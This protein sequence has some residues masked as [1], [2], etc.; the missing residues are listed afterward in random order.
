MHGFSV[1]V[2]QNR[3]SPEE[4]YSRAQNQSLLNSALVRDNWVL[5]ILFQPFGYRQ[6]GP[7]QLGPRTI[8]LRV[9]KELF[10]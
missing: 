8:R 3:A 6:F 10:H 1:L 7:G 2:Y 4:T 5:P 9:N